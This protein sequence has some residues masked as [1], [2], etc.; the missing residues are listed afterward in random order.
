MDPYDLSV[1]VLKVPSA[2]ANLFLDQ[3]SWNL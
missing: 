1:C 2:L 3:K